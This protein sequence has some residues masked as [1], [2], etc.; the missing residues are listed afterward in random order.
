MSKAELLIITLQFLS[1]IAAAMGLGLVVTSIIK[2]LFN[3]DSQPLPLST[4]GGAAL[5]VGLGSLGN[6]WLVIGLLG[7]FT[8][9]VLLVSVLAVLALSANH[10]K[11]FARQ[12][13]SKI[14]QEKI[15]KNFI[16][17]VAFGL[18]I[19]AIMIAVFLAAMQPPHA[20]DELHYHFPEARLIV[21]NQ[22]VPLTIGSHYFYG[23][24]PKLMEV[25]FAS[26]IALS[27][28]ALAHAIHVAFLLG[29]II[30]VVGI[31]TRH[32]SLKTGLLAALLV[33]LYD[34]FTWNASVGFVD[35]ATVSLEIGAL[36]LASSWVMTKDKLAL[37]ISGVLLGLALSVKYSPLA[38]A[39]FIVITVA[40]VLAG[41]RKRSLITIVKTLTPW[42]LL[43]GLFG[44]FWYIKNLIR[45]GNPF[46]PLYFGHRGVDELQYQGLINAIQEFGSRNLGSFLRFPKR[47][48]TFN[49]LP[50][51]FSFYLPFFALFI[52]QSKTFHIVLLIYFLLYLPYWFFLATHQHRFLMPAIV[53][54]L[55]VSAIFITNLKRW[56]TVAVVVGLV[57]SAVLLNRY[58]APFY[59]PNSWSEFIETKLRT[60]ERKYALGLL[61]E[62]EFLNKRF[63]CQYAIIETLYLK[64]WTG[65]VID[66]WSIWHAPSVAFYTKNNRF[67][68]F[69]FDPSDQTLDVPQM[70]RDQGL[71]FIYFDEEVK[72]RHLGNP[73]PEVIDYR[74]GRDVA[75]D[76]L[77][78]YS[79]LVYENG[80]CKLYEI[81]FLKLTIARNRAKATD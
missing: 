10:L 39:L 53:A 81:D 71:R 27:G 43:V 80:I 46:Y 51:Y 2:R 25:M 12:V 76:Y 16:W 48:L 9:E 44:G 29:F 33:L 45:F 42:A 62:S 3:R 13:I 21:S 67:S 6:I 60:D 65:N 7:H 54:G 32:Y 31:L 56:V 61:N 79:N 77:L 74:T 78:K 30:L 63:G 18:P 59:H 1:I 17:L 24:I 72:A 15:K 8:K 52:K 14:T 26:G 68:Q 58:V 66:N 64:G 40:L 70:L 22:Q 36:L 41:Q 49:L 28:Y 35:T 11:H 23:N 37:L 69:K 20:T 75:E 57:I 55:I 73:D 47:Y 34:E 19:V 5:L 38:T 50:V 4:L